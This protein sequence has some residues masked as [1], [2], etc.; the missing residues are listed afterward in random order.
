[1]AF[2][3]W[4]LGYGIQALGFKI[5]GLGLGPH[6][7]GLGFWPRSRGLEGSETSTRM[8][9]M[10]LT[11]DTHA[12]TYTKQMYKSILPHIVTPVF[13]NGPTLALSEASKASNLKDLGNSTHKSEDHTGYSDCRA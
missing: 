12:N 5:F 3:A 7:W 4:G 1:M 13:R 9:S 10:F 6:A 11:T 2:R 8:Y